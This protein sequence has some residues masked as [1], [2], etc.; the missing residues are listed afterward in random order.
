M[1]A[2]LG[3]SSEQFYRQY[4]R[5]LNGSWSLREKSTPHGYD[6][7]LLDRES[8]PGKALCSAY[9][10]RPKQCRTWPFWWVNTR[11]KKDWDEAKN[12]TPC[13]GMDEGELVTLGTIRKKLNS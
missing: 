12:S 8:T 7:V 11:S 9:G 4:A 1:A 3:I 10:D 5:K 2:R 6:C 13:P